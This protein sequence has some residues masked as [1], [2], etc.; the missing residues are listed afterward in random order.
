ML[1]Q[2]ER[3]RSF[4]LEKAKEGVW[5]ILWG[6]VKKVVIADNIARVTDTLFNPDHHQLGSSL[7]MAAAYAFTIQIYCDFSGYTDIARGCRALLDLNC[8]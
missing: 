4:D 1:P 6:L 5:L 3:P 2:I 8:L 7:A